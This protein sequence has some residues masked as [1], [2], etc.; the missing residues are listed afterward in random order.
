VRKPDDITLTRQQRETI[1][2]HAL[3]ALRASGALGHFPTD[4]S[5]VMNVSKVTEIQENVLGNPGFLERMRQKAGGVLRS[6]LSKVVGLFDAK[7]GEIFIDRTLHLVKQTFIRLHETAHAYLPWQR[8]MYAVVED[9]AISIDPDVAELFDRE[10]NVFASEV[11]FQ[12]DSFITEATDHPFDIFVPVKLSKKYGASV[13]SSVRQYVTKN[14]RTCAVLVLDPPQLVPNDGFRAALRRPIYSDEFQ[15][16]FSSV[17][18]PDY[19][20]PDGDIGAMIPVQ[21]RRASGKRQI[22]LV[23]ANGDRHECVAEAFT[24]TYQVFILIHV[25]KAL[26]AKTVLV[27]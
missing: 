2:T 6:A 21:G 25:V 22:E 15:R 26:T 23:D 7:A 9:C 12:V 18:W 5:A 19:F 16:Q 1:R 24:Q 13:Y 8:P 11:L 14:H 20:T 3:R 27:A 17:T 4:V 10:A